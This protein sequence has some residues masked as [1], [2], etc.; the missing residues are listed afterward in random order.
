MHLKDEIVRVKLENARLKQQL[1][2]TT[3]KLRRILPKWRIHERIRGDAGLI[4][5]VL[6]KTDSFYRRRGQ[7]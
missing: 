7:A 6:K 3:V 4:H 2:K 1:F 5:G